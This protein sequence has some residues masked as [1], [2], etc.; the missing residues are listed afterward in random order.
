MPVILKKVL[1]FFCP[2]FVLLCGSSAPEHE[3]H[4]SQPTEPLKSSF[5]Q[6]I[7]K[8]KKKSKNNNNTKKPKQTKKPPNQTKKIKKKNKSEQGH[9]A[10]EKKLLPAT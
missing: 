3:F 2:K 10:D 8:T 4:L 5:F 6:K 9:N 7:N 1:G